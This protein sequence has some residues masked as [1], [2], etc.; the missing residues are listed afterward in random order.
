[1]PNL[2]K[3]QKTY[4]VISGD[5]SIDGSGL[6]QL[7][8]EVERAMSSQYKPVG[9]VFVSGSIGHQA[10]MRQYLGPHSMGPG[11][12]EHI[13]TLLTPTTPSANLLGANTN[14]EKN[15][16]VTPTTAENLASIF[17]SSSAAKNNGTASGGAGGKRK[18][19]RKSM[20]RKKSR[21][22]RR[23]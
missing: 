14:S 4:L 19:S 10:V 21:N 23:H 8:K 11:Y 3:P 13:R 1:M 17:S 9:G 6:S 5:L 22:T 12:P 2:T 7:E 20:P 15:L 18:N 16:L